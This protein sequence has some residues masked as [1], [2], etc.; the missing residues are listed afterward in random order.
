MLRAGDC[1][2]IVNE[3]DV[4]GLKIK[5]IARLIHHHQEQNIKLFVWR[6]SND[7]EEEQKEAGVAIKGP[8]PDV[9]S[10]LANALS[11]V[12]RNSISFIIPLSTD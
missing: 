11:G 6:Y 12:V 5:A 8:L 4:I 9:A 10:K 1:L 7:E 2:T 3:K